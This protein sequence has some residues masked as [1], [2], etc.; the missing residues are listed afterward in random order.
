MTQ[1]DVLALVR[2]AR[3]YPTAADALLSAAERIATNGDTRR[4]V[5][6]PITVDSTIAFPLDVFCTYKGQKYHGTLHKDRTVTVN[7]VTYGKP[8]PAAMS[9]TN[10]NVNGLRWWWYKDPTSG[11]I[12]QIKDLEVRGLI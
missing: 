2:L 11:V 8:S 12:R 4:S 10:N 7:G 3:R 5:P 1:Q 6:A 9:I